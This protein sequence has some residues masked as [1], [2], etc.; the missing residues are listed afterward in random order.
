MYVKIYI[1]DE[2]EVKKK[3]TKNTKDSLNAKSKF[4]Y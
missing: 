2:R 1:K 4:A 3:L